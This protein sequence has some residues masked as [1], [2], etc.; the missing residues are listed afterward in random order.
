[1]ASKYFSVMYYYFTPGSGSKNS[2][3]FSGKVASESEK[4]VM[5]ILEN[6]H[7]GKEIELRKI[8]WK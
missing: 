6:K 3:T 1:M 2:T 7:P 5:Q 4:L 8:T